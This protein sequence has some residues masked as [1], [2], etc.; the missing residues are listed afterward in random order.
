MMTITG[1]R[2][3]V[4][5]VGGGPAGLAC[6]IAL[7]QR[8]ID[9]TVIEALGG[10]GI[11][12]SCGEGLMPDSLSVLRELGVAIDEA[13]GHPFRGIRFANATHRADADFPDGVGVGMRRVK[14]HHRLAQ[15][16]EEAGVRLRWR[17]RAQ[18]VDNKRMLVEG[19]EVRFR[20]LVAADGIGSGVRRWAGLDAS[21]RE[22]VRFGFRRHY[23]I[24]P[25]SEYVEVHWGLRGQLYV[26]PVGKDSVCVVAVTRDAPEDRWDLLEDFPEI[27]ER[28]RD[29][30]LMSQQRGA[31]TAT[32]KLRGVARGSVA[33][34]GDASGSV[35][36]ITGEGLAIS[37]R[38]ALALAD[39]VV[40]G[41]LER[42]ADAHDEI[43]RLP[44]TMSRLMLTM[45]RWPSLEKRAL[46]V[47]A[48]S[49]WL[50]EGLLRVHIGEESLGR[51]VLRNGVRLGWGLM[52]PTLDISVPA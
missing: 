37:F 10:P 15:R 23:K 21:R 50:F 4:A 30:L 41:D 49:P 44:H 17:S 24:A 47:F 12:K 52:R 48:E 46:A 35:D 42:Y 20:Y 7:R 38:Q 8:G 3:D 45:D 1:Q 16:A 25:W 51:F 36:A 28:L 11:E 33:L 6:G 13:E 31:V 9:C 5:I 32:R 2:T 29:A 18:L 14:L 39:A 27:A 34:I 43:G 26:T 40:A 22:S 19:E